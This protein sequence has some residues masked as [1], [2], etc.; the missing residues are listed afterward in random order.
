MN[1]EELR[2]QAETEGRYF[3]GRILMGEVS[4]GLGTSKEEYGEA[5]R[6]AGEANVSFDLVALEACGRFLPERTIKTLPPC[7]QQVYALNEPTSYANVDYSA[8]LREA[9]GR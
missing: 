4:N 5:L 2:K 6:Q 9:R 7:V 3:L 1:S 8:R